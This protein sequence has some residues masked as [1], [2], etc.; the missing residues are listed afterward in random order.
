MLFSFVD[1]LL[2]YACQQYLGITRLRNYNPRNDGNLAYYVIDT[3]DNWKKWKKQKKRKRY[4]E[5]TNHPFHETPIIR[6]SFLP[7]SNHEI[8][9]HRKQVVARGS[10]LRREMISSRRV[11]RVAGNFGSK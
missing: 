2:V 1:L 4:V 7:A 10:V 11:N 3:S 5:E 9:L 6:K 8:D